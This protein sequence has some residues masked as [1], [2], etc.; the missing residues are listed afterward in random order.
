MPRKAAQDGVGETPS[1]NYYGYLMVTT[2]IIVAILVFAVLIYRKMWER[3]DSSPTSVVIAGD[4]RVFGTDAFGRQRVSTPFTL[5]DNKNIHIT[6]S[7]YVDRLVSGGTITHAPD[8]AAFLLTVPPTTGAVASRQTRMYYNYMPG[9]SQLILC[10]FQ[11]GDMVSGVIRRVGYFDDEN[12]LFLEQNGVAG[13]VY[14]VRRETTGGVVREHRVPQADW[15]GGGSGW[16]FSKAQL[17]KID[18]QWLGVG[19][20]RFF[21]SDGSDDIITSIFIANVNDT[22]SMT[23]PNLPV[24][25]EIVNEGYTGGTAPVSLKMICSTVISEGGYAEVGV[26]RSVTS[27]IVPRRIVDGGDEIPIVA[28]RLKNLFEG[29][30][31]RYFVRP[32]E[33]E[34]YVENHP[35]AY[36]IIRVDS[37]STQVVGGAWVSAAPD[38][39]VEYNT[40][41]TGVVSGV[42]DQ[43]LMTGYV[44]AS[45]PKKSSESQNFQTPTSAKREFISQNLDSTDSMAFVIVVT[46]LGSG[47]NVNSDVYA[48]IQWREIF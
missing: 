31:N 30:P 39:P 44:T 33:Y 28:L 40:T 8:E 27:G 2:A 17:L 35:V 20:I 18:F 11:F 5:G 43:I 16:D 32:G 37:S 34:I 48:S 3:G 14:A 9:K 7:E 41:A 22:V 46:A 23:S 25:Y 24:R 13:V 36:R 21:L 15:V 10:S 29:R 12:G 26:D 4:N 42:G 38:S 6:D 19:K 45:A 1:H 47:T